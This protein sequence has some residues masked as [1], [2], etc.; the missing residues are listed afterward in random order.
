MIPNKSDSRNRTK[1]FLAWF[2]IALC[3]LGPSNF[4][5]K[6]YKVPPHRKFANYFATYSM[7]IVGNM[8]KHFPDSEET[9]KG[10][11]NHQRQGVCFT[12]P[13][14]FEESSASSEIEKK[15]RNVY[16][17]VVDLWKPKNYLYRPN[18]SLS[19]H[20]PE[21]SKVCHGNGN[22]IC[23][24]NLV[25][26]NQEQDWPRVNKSPQNTTEKG[27]DRQLGLK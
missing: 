16:V 26:S 20:C 7:L 8:N 15:E 14:N 11:M 10:H 5:I 1:Q 9:A 17:N 4:K 18:W 6:G 21:W 22:N 13:K 23:Q 27:Q 2:N 19:H 12:K 3:Y 24:C 25:V